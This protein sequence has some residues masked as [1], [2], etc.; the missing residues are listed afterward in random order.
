[1]TMPV[2]DGRQAYEQI[3]ALHP[4][5]PVIFSSGYDEQDMG[6][7]ADDPHVTFLAKPYRAETLTAR[8]REVL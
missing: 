1:M 2:L 5:V 7:T 3:R 4:A 8:V 6:R